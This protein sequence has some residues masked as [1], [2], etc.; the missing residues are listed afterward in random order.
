MRANDQPVAASIAGL[1]TGTGC[2]VCPAESST[3]ALAIR[4]QTTFF[5]CGPFLRRWPR[6]AGAGR[7][8]GAGIGALLDAAAP[9]FY[10]YTNI[11]E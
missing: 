1:L 9:G 7:V 10:G 4:H 5:P 3:P 2:R 6:R 11:I 8:R